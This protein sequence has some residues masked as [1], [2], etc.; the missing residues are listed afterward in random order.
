MKRITITVILAILAVLSFLILKPILLSLIFG[1]ILAVVFS[2]IYTFVFKYLKSKNLSAAITCGFL[3]IL[4]I[5]PF[6]LLTPIFVKQSFE[7]YR[8]SQQVDY[9]TPLKT[10]FP[11]FFSS[12]QFSAEMGSILHSFVTKLAN[13][14]VNSLSKLILNFPTILLQ[15]FVVFFTFFFVIRDRESFVSYTKNV[16]PFSKDLKEKLFKSSKDI[17]LSVV[18]GQIVIGTIQGVVVAI[19]FFVFGIKNAILLSLLVILAGLF[20]V[21]G[22]TIVWLPVVIYLLIAGNTIPAV[23]IAFFGVVSNFVDNILRPI[24]VSRLTRIHPLLILIG[25]IGGLFFFGILGFVLGPLILSYAFIM[26]EVYR[27]KKIEGI[28]IR[29]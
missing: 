14:F 15:F 6:W 9:I 12:E 4:I 8:V 17:T 16:L 25:M 7:V 27:G 1:I 5:T 18:Y 10:I 23:G 21:I 22:T 13:S 20:P 19:G 28:F 26:L 2:P 24:L 3:I 29:E 11:S